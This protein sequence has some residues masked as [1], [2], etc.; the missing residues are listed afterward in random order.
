MP[1]QEIR[2][3]EFPSIEAARREWPIERWEKEGHPK[4]WCLVEKNNAIEVQVDIGYGYIRIVQANTRK[5]LGQGK[6]MA[7]TE[8]YEWVVLDRDYYGC[9]KYIWS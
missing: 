4:Q 9:P 7:H 8:N 3:L 2:E 1:Q 6:Y 5:V